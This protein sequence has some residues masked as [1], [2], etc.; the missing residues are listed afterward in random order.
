LF[1]QVNTTLTVAHGHPLLVLS[2]GS[3]CQSNG[4]GD[5]GFKRAT[6]IRFICDQNV[7]S[8]GTPRLIAQLPP[9]DN[10]ACALFV[11]WRTHVACPTSKPESAGGVL[12]IFGVIT[13]IALLV[14]IIGATFYNRVVLGLRGWE[15]LPTFS[16]SGARDFL[17]ECVARRSHADSTQPSWGSWRN[18]RYRSGYGRMATEE[19]AIANTRFSLDDDEEGA[20]DAQPLS[21]VMPP[22]SGDEISRL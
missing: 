3:P 8:R 17:S 20:R 1:S 13:F 18:S 19:E 9:D 22:E 11:E 15:Q 21:N 6:A 2:G 7:F 4:S 14:Y 10:A 12:L 16:L 5:S